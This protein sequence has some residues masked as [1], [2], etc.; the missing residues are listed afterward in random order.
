[1]AFHIGCARFAKKF[2][3]L[4]SEI[5]R[6]WICFTCVSL[7]H[8]KI[9]LLFFSLLFAYF[10]FK[11][12]AYFRFKF[13]ASL[14][15]SNFRF[16]AKRSKAKLKSIFSLFSFFFALHFSLPFRAPHLFSYQSPIHWAL[17][18]GNGNTLKKRRWQH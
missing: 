7:F 4:I 10:R 17:Q 13:F 8:Y 12:F 15:F 9:S 16:E 11:F 14:C 6:I 2:F 1:M 3:S 5:K 18:T